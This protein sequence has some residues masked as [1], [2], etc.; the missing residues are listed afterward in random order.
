[1]RIIAIVTAMLFIVFMPSGAGT[2]VITDHSP[3]D[4]FEAKILHSSQADY[5]V[6]Q[7]NLLPEKQREQAVGFIDNVKTFENVWKVFKSGESVPKIDFRANL[8]LFAFD[9]KI[10][11]ISED[12]GV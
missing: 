8:V 12:G 11:K 6:A 3:Q 9:G 7:L 5:P 1:M 4:G 10:Y 2:L